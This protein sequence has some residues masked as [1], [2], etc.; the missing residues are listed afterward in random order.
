MPE[1]IRSGLLNNKIYYAHARSLLS[2]K[3]QKLMITIYNKIVKNKLSIRQTEGLIKGLK[4]K[5]NLKK[6]AKEF[7]NEEEILT[8]KLRTKVVIKS[9]KKNGKITI[10]FT[11]KKE[12]QQ[13]I[14]KIK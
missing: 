14:E 9:D 10:S 5:K 3:K 4:N 7:L 2:V 6:K 13:I 1:I 11:S 8:A 12:L